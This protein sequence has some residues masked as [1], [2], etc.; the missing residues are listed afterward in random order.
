MIRP[1]PEVNETGFVCG[2]RWV[3]EGENRWRKSNVGANITEFKK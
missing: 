2:D 1:M 3:P